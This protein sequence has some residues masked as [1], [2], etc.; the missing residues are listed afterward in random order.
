M[1]GAVFGDADFDGAD[2]RSA[3]LTGAIIAGADLS[4]ARGLTQ[5]QLDSAC[6]DNRT[7]APPG[8]TARSCHHFPIPRMAVAIPNPPAPPPPPKPP[9][10]LVG[11]E[12]KP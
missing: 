5:E 12:P 6:A 11:A 9:R 1:T 4:R 2:F 10:Y 8:L 3:E 7:K